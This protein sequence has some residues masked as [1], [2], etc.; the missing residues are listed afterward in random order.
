MKCG[1][2][3][4][5]KDLQKK[6]GQGL[7]DRDHVPSK[8]AL[9]EAAKRIAARLRPPVTLT[10]AMKSTISALADT[11]AIPKPLHQ[12]HSATYGGRSDPETDAKDLNKAA[13]RDLDEIQEHWGKHD[14]DC[15]EAYAEAAD[16]IRAK[17]DND[18]DY[19]KKWLTDIIKGKIT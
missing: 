5:Y 14:P 12:G 10:E 6:T 3:G 15:A 9:K 7:L 17:I 18:P 16:E 11:I 2:A 19:Y 8:S 4:A 13:K 1:E